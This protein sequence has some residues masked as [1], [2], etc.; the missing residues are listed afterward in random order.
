MEI[1]G[2][3]YKQNSKKISRLPEQNFN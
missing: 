2:K 1:F 3:C